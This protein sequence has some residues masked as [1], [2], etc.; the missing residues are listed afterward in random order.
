MIR[1]FN[2]NWSLLVENLRQHYKTLAI[3]MHET[4]IAYQ[5][6]ERL[7]IGTT[8]QPRFDMGIRLLNLHLDKCGIDKH[9]QLLM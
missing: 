2:I 3:C 7:Y 4:G 6:L 1:T 9:K 5:T 8:R